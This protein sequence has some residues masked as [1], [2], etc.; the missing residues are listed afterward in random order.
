MG[1]GAASVLAESSD[2]RFEQDVLGAGGPVLVEFFATWCGSCR[3]FAPT[4]EAVAVEYAGRVPVVTVNADENPESVRRY[5]VSSTPTLVLFAGGEP[6]GTLVG[7]Q[8]ADAVRALLDPALEPEATDRAA[9]APM[10]APGDA[11]TLPTAEQPLREAEFDQLF[12]SAL[13]GLQRPDPARL[14]LYLDPEAEASAR[15]L[16]ARESSCCSFFDFELGSEEG[17]L[18]VDVRVPQDRVPV[19]DG[20][21]RQAESAR[22]SAGAGSEAIA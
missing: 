8:P 14:R 18:V 16:V 3:R 2:V 1:G 21:A 17:R 22:T 12:A 7:A 13:R 5:G 15:D 6:V 4:L 19:L 20:I 9:P 10:W 11:C